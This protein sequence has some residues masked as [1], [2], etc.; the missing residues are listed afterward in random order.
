MVRGVLTL[1]AEQ[2]FAK[3]ARHA[4]NSGGTGLTYLAALCE[5]VARLGALLAARLAPT[6]QE[7]LPGLSPGAA[8]LMLDVLG[9][10]LAAELELHARGALAEARTL[11]RHLAHAEARLRLGGAAPPPLL[12][13]RALGA[14]RDAWL[15]QQHT[16]FYKVLD[17]LILIRTLT[18]TNPNSNPNPNPKPHPT[19][20]P[21]PLPLTQVL[22]S[23]LE[24][25][26]WTPV[27]A[28]KRI[29]ASL[30]DLFQCLSQTAHFYLDSLSQPWPG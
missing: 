10:L 12:D 2:L 20:T 19:P 14:M 17:T 22:D 11:L 4:A 21:L 15:A 8:P 7:V 29:S 25:E 9:A 26:E 13:C 16:A 27:Y 6:V 5:A 24:Q 1:A 28:T 3:T 18:L 30:V 23:A